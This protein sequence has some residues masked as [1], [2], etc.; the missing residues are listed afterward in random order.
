MIAEGAALIMFKS[1]P[2]HHELMSLNFIA[3][4]SKSLC[5]LRVQLFAQQHS[6]FA[7]KVRS[8]S[9]EQGSAGVMLCGDTNK[10]GS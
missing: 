9:H 3:V 5:S 7:P 1:F 8:S 10:S 4:I 6:L 2:D